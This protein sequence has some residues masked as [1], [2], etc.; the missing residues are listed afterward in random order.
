MKLKHLKERTLYLELLL[1]IGFVLV[2]L[3]VRFKS[4]IAHVRKT[5]LSIIKNNDL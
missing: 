5:F 2:L 4:S 3:M 1:S